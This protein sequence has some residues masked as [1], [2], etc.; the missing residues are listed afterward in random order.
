MPTT[1]STLV[2]PSVVV[3]VQVLLSPASPSPLPSVVA[4]AAAP[5]PESSTVDVKSTPVASA[6]VGE[7]ASNCTVI[8]LLAVT[9][10]VRSTLILLP[11]VLFV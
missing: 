10:V 2:P 7:F 6:L 8:L 4:W 5:V 11:D 9:F 3:T 1:R